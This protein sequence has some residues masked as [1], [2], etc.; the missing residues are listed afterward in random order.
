[1]FGIGLGEIL[2]IIFIVFLISP[3]EVPKVMR[4]IGEFFGLIEKIKKDIIELKEDVEDIVKEAE[5]KNDVD[6]IA[7]ETKIRDETHFK[8]LNKPNKKIVKK[9]KLFK[10]K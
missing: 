4:K 9:I 5:I 7:K 1:M 2:L 8:E 3:R 10:K 6:E